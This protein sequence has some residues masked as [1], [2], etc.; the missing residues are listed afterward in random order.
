MAEALADAAVGRLPVAVRHAREDLQR[1][2]AVG[3]NQLQRHPLR[4]WSL[5]WSTIAPS[6]LPSLR[7]S[8]RTSTRPHGSR[9][10]G[11]VLFEKGAGFVDDWAAPAARANSKRLSQRHA[12][13]PQNPPCFA[14]DPTVDGVV[15]AFASAN[16][17]TR[18]TPSRLMS[19][20]T[21]KLSSMIPSPLRA[22]VR[23]RVPP[24]SSSAGRRVRPPSC[25]VRCTGATNAG[26]K[27]L[28]RDSPP[29]R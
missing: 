25:P 26:F 2:C 8:P 24:V 21:S 5:P 9:L 13:F 17:C 10:P 4:D 20:S 14:A 7:P 19:A 3:T 23:V 22:P 6:V 28:P 11:S 12:R 1:G 15:P 16:S 27:R 18:R 29:G